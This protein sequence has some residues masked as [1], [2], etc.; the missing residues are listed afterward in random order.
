MPKLPNSELTPE[1][2]FQRV[3]TILA[4]AVLRYQ[5]H[6]PEISGESFYHETGFQIGIGMQYESR[7]G[8]LPVFFHN[9]ED[10]VQS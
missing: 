5:R 2:R 7:L 6:S 3:A 1:Q 8:V 9:C 4:K 10:S